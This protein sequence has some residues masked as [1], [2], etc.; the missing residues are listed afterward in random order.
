MSGLTLEIEFLTGA[1]RAALP[2]TTTPEWPPHPER[3][4]SALVQ[5]WGDGDKPGNEKAAL[6]WLERI[7]APVIEADPLTSISMRTAPSV[8]V[9]PNDFEI[10]DPARPLSWPIDSK[11]GG[12]KSVGAIAWAG[13]EPGIRS[14]SFRQ[15]R[16][17]QAVV[18]PT[19]TVRMFWTAAPPR[20]VSAALGALAS[21]VASLGHSSSLTR[22]ALRETASP[23]DK[24]R[25]WHPDADGQV[26]LRV[27]Y[28]GRLADLERWHVADERPRSLATHRYRSPGRET[29]GPVPE[30]VFGPDW[31]IFEGANGFQPDILAFAHV[32]KRVR[33]ALMT[34]SPVQPV[35]EIVS[36]HAPGGSP[37]QVPHLAVVPLLDVGWEHSGGD[38][39][40]FA[41]LLPRRLPA[42]I[43]TLVLRTV[44]RFVQTADD[45]EFRA[46]VQLT[47]ERSWEVQRSASPS[48]ASLRPSRWCAASDAWMS[49]TPVVLDRFPAEDN[50]IESAQL[51][52]KACLNIG[53]PE[54]VEVELHKHSGVRGAPTSYPSRG[55]QLRPNWSFPRDSKLRDRPRRH[56]VIRF[57]EPVRGPVI[58]GAGRFQG[59]GLCLPIVEPN[60]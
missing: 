51:V 52:A 50:P 56:V 31:Q 57:A 27:P 37:S 43:R 49:A 55:S 44:A 4:F 6:E 40:G 26:P 28:R 54:P 16:T 59:F 45:G 1:Y 53:L 8:F 7:E 36:G 48:R 60:P 19:P 10:P 21:R 25:L 18:P 22:V 23:P 15:P 2:D 20:E 30:G 24:G 11:T 47:R 39:L 9:P 5:A 58:L 34:V 17:F 3:V 33:D 13:I 14:T 35:P 32:A 12:L 38:L 46:T 29:A 41:L 42:D